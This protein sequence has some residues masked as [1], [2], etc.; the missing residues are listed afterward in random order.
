MIKYSNIL[1]LILIII[2]SIKIKN[3][4]IIMEKYDIKVKTGEKIGLAS[5][6]NVTVDA[7]ALSNSVKKKS[8]LIQE[9]NNEVNNRNIQIANINTDI[10]NKIT[11]TDKLLEESNKALAKLT[12]SL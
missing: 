2:I 1:I 11:K 6:D 3:N 9:L 10:T 8:E 4:I 7:V 5:K 12:S